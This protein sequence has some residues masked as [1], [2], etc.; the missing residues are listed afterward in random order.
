MLNKL[1]VTQKGVLLVSIPVLFEFMFAGGLYYLVDRAQTNRE[2]FAESKE[3]L[4]RTMDLQMTMVRSTMAAFGSG[5]GLINEKELASARQILDQARWSFAD[6]AEKRPHMKSNLR[7][8][9]AC[10]DMSEAW[11]LKAEK[12]FKDKNIPRNQRFAHLREDGYELAARGRPVLARIIES[13]SRIQKQEPASQRQDQ[14]LIALMVVLGLGTNA[15]LAIVLAKVFGRDFIERLKSISNNA[16]LLIQDSQL[17]SVLHGNDEIVALDQALHFA[18]NQIREARRKELAILEN[19]AD[20]ICSIDRDFAFVT[21]GA[22]ARKCWGREPMDLEGKDIREF[23]SK[24][25]SRLF[26]DMVERAIASPRSKFEC[27]TRFLRQSENSAPCDIRWT[28]TT[29]DNDNRVYLTARDISAEKALERM[30]ENF[31]ATINHDIRTPLTSVHGSLELTLAGVGGPLSQSQTT[32]LQ[33]T[34]REVDDLASSINMMLD[35]ERQKHAATPE[36]SQ[37]SL[38]DCL[39]QCYGCLPEH[40]RAH[41]I[42]P[43]Q[44]HE[45]LSGADRLSR[46]IAALAQIISLLRA[47]DSPIELRFADLSETREIAI[48]MLWKG[49]ALAPQMMPLLTEEMQVAMMLTVK[50][51]AAALPLKLARLLLAQ[52]NTALIYR[53]PSDSEFAFE[54]ALPLADSSRHMAV[55]NAD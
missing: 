20:V 38:L 31:V 16:T 34:L 47:E 30:R 49:S 32:Q 8:A 52:L 48:Q 54:F 1:S 28:A 11:I 17:P 33:S 43:Q 2:R 51:S 24:A 4:S 10:C 39:T 14:L 41:M 22:S 21:V 13:E 50:P 3:L 5:D 36:L 6:G 26:Q 40:V 55:A 27:D 44:D 29:E 46:A 7:E 37:I 35:M 9:Y 12:I 15:T 42:F 45:V 23:L 25:D 18:A 53:P 19:A